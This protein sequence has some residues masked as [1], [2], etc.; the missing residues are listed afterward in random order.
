MSNALARE[1]ARELRGNWHFVGSVEE[2]VEA[3]SEM[4]ELQRIV[5]GR[6]SYE[7]LNSRQIA[8]V[9]EIP[10]DRVTRICLEA[11]ETLIVHPPNA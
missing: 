3:L 2:V 9:M 6:R 8:V 4:S 7:G 10:E 5:V 11:I 1:T